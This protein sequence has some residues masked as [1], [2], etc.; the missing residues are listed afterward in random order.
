MTPDT[1]QTIAAYLA[2]AVPATV[3]IANF[4]KIAME[5]LQQ[6]H[7]I[8]EAQIQLSHQ[9]T[10]HY[11]DRALDPAVPLA[12]RH[13]LLRFLATPDVKGARL[14]TWARSELERVGGLVDETNRAVVVAEENLRAAQSAVELERAE[15]KLAEAVRKQRSL[16]EQPTTPPVTAAAIRA[17]LIDEKKLNGIEMPDADLRTAQILYREL[18]GANFK[19]TDF[20]SA[21]LQGCD[22]RAAD[23]SG[24]TLVDTTLYVADLRGAN[25]SNVKMTSCDLRQARLEGADLRGAAIVDCSSCRLGRRRKPNRF[26]PRPK[27][28]LRRLRVLHPTKALRAEIAPSSRLPL[29]TFVLRYS[30]GKRCWASYVSPTYR[31]QCWSAHKR[32]SA[33]GQTTKI[34][35]RRF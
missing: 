24:A 27:A 30:R 33:Y 1:V 12:I 16:L 9:I 23:M 18:R 11:L 21:S 32:H 3:A 25:L 6:R 15:R 20:T 17:G 10:T 22:L 34:Q 28:P 13:Q 14:S 29:A 19:N 2:L 31:A 35:V 8:G 26:N 5:W 4:A 7:K